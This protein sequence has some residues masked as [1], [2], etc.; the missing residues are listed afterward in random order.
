MISLLIFADL[1]AAVVATKNRFLSDGTTRMAVKRLTMRRARQA[2]YMTQG[3]LQRMA[4]LVTQCRQPRQ[5]KRRWSIDKTV[6]GLTCSRALPVPLALDVMAPHTTVIWTWI[7]KHTDSKHK[8]LALDIMAPHTTGIWTWISKHTESKH[9]NLALDIMAPHTTDIWT[10][11]RK[12]TESKHENL[13]LDVMAP[14]TT[15]IWTRFSKHTLS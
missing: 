6:Q 15:G 8:N 7:S 5:R 11:I 12:H 10:W 2:V 13:A 4:K 1:V 3:G 14:H 9:K